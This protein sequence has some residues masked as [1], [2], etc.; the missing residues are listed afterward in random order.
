MFLLNSYYNYTSEIVS[1]FTIQNVSIK[2][3]EK[4]SFAE[5]YMDLQYKMFLLNKS[6][7]R[8]VT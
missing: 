4:K 2:L 5:M 6:I 7:N 3:E 8:Y 1:A